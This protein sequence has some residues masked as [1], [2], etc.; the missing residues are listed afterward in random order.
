MDPIQGPVTF[1]DVAVYFSQEEWKLLDEAQRLL[2]R[3]VLL[4][5]FA[6]VASLVSFCYV[7]HHQE[8]FDLTEQLHTQQDIMSTAD[9]GQSSAT[10]LSP[11]SNR[12]LT[13]EK[14]VTRAATVLLAF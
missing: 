10:S 1:E 12:K 5:T 3:D 13:L 2:Y 14:D 4:E 7:F 9:V 6:L 11:F 8:P